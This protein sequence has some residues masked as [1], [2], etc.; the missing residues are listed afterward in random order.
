MG[1][2]RSPSFLPFLVSPVFSH[3]IQPS[4]GTSQ[5]IIIIFSSP[6]LFIT[7]MARTK[8]KSSSSEPISAEEQKPS[9]VGQY[10]I[11]YDK[12]DG[13]EILGF[14]TGS[15]LTLNI[16]PT[17]NPH[18]D[19]ANFRLQTTKNP[20]PCATSFE[21]EELV[22]YE[23][24]D[25]D[26]PESSRYDGGPE[27]AE[28]FERIGSEEIE[29]QWCGWPMRPGAGRTLEF[30]FLRRTE[31]MTY[32]FAPKTVFGGKG[33]IKFMNDDMHSLT[34]VIDLEEYRGRSVPFT[35]R[36]VEKMP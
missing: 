17:H 35:G 15:T 27:W 33:T 19:K 36:K 11:T 10:I 7:K 20:C 6:T 32:D 1:Y 12:S 31:N 24:V 23:G 2:Y 30:E 29:C 21:L 13:H 14:D 8:P 5:I 3:F 28:F 26:T 25:D 9:P 22:Y 4:L 34:G 18:T 16:H